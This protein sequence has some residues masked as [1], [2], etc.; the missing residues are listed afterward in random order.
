MFCCPNNIHLKFSESCESCLIYPVPEKYWYCYWYNRRE[1]F[2]NIQALNI[3]LVLSL[4]VRVC[5][6]TG[7]CVG[8]YTCLIYTS[9]IT[10]VLLPCLLVCSFIQVNTTYFCCIS[11]SHFSL[12][13]RQNWDMESM[14]QFLMLSSKSINEFRL[15]L[16]CALF[17][18]KFVE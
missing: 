12:S 16:S 5:V 6:C 7:V 15:T 2:H 13:F 10:N 4:A 11:I 17:T 18:L 3:Q 1:P 14:I 8:P 9:W